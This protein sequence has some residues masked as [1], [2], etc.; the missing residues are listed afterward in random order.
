MHRQEFLP[1]PELDQTP[2]AHA[3]S[4]KPL[5]I[6][7][8][9]LFAVILVAGTAVRIHARDELHEQTVAAAIPTVN[10]VHPG[11]QAAD[12]LTL[13]GRLQAWYQAPVYA[14]TNGYL[15][16][17]LVDIGQQVHAGQLLAE[18]ETPDVDQQLAA[19]RAALGT[20]DAQQQLAR[21]TTSRWD[22]LVAQHAVSQQ[23]ADERR[24]DFAARQAMRKEASANV[25]RLQT[26]SGFKHIVA[27]FD[28]VVTSRSTDIG[29]LIVAGTSTTQP[30][31][32]VSDV[33]RLRLYV[34]VPQAYV[35]RMASEGSA[36]F[37][38]PDH[39]GQVFTAQVIRSAAAI[40]PQSGAMLL[41][42]VYDNSQGLL[43]PGA[44]AQISFTLDASGQADAH[45]G[46]IPVSS[47][48]FRKEGS[49]VAIV[50]QRGRVR[51]QPVTV[52]TDFGTEL[53]VTGIQPHDWIIDNPADDIAAGDQVKPAPAGGA[54][55]A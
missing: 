43:K 41:Q 29:A 25:E 7:G 28:G 9:L 47:L 39:P 20:A 35:T 30:L 3:P 14:R 16:R 38:V 55:H 6:G 51:I 8:S 52:V 42:L 54:G 33:K 13:P 10:V 24:G 37:T 21:T 50:D 26:L 1:M 2:A 11:G 5:L 22:R 17:W 4:F 46:R 49:S 19:A 31:F 23:D 34:S 32:T 45:G 12:V 48:L 36:H 40:D 53:E 44:Y 15:R 18:I 27:P